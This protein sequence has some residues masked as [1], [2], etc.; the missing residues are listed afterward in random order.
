MKIIHAEDRWRDDGQIV[1]ND[2]LDIGALG[3]KRMVDQV[4]DNNVDVLS[5]LELSF[6]Y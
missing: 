5:R 6:P 2:F 3:T 4:L 1:A